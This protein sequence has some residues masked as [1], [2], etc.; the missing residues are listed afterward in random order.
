MTHHQFRTGDRAIVVRPEQP[1][2]HRGGEKVTVL[3][4]HAPAAGTDRADQLLKVV[5]E[6]GEIV[7]VWASELDPA[8]A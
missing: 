4:I 1:T 2:G 5:D 6:S 3:S 8:E 7:G